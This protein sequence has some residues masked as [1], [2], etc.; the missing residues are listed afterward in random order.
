MKKIDENLSQIFDIEPLEKTQITDIVP[1]MEEDSDQDLES[2]FNFA[3]S[4]IKHLLRRGDVAIDNLLRVADE[5]EHPRAY[6]VAANF[7]KT[8][9]DLNKDLLDIRKKKNELS[10]KTTVENNTTTIDKAVF[11]GSTTD[12]IKLIKDKKEG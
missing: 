8:V 12:L 7:I 3:R 5:S 10:G 2:D 11:V 9:A 6:E 4:N 1:I